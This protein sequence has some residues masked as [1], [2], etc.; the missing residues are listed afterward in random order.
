MLFQPMHAARGVNMATANT[1]WVMFF[2]VYALQVYKKTTPLA[3][4][5]RKTETIR[6]FFDMR[7]WKYLF[8]TFFIPI[9]RIKAMY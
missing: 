4:Y 1:V 2:M 8:F 3:N 9:L 6:M 7:R 5:W